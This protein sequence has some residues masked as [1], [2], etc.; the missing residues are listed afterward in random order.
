MKYNSLRAL[1]MALGVLAWLAASPS[2]GATNTIFANGV[3]WSTN[4]YNPDVTIGVGDYDKDPV[5]PNTSPVWTI[6][7]VSAT[8]TLT[9]N[10]LR[11]DTSAAGASLAFRQTQN[12]DATQDTT[13]EFRLRIIEHSGSS[14]AGSV[15]FANGAKWQNM[16]FSTNSVLLSGS[17]SPVSGDYTQWTL[18]RITLEDMTTTPTA[19]LYINNQTNVF[20]TSTTFNSAGINY[21]QFGDGSTSSSFESGIIEW[22]FVRWTSTGA[23][24]APEPSAAALL[25]LGALLF[26]ARRRMRRKG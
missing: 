7:N 14:Y 13:I 4:Y 11:I 1:T 3:D 20:S 10:A 19:K 8:R 16:Y 2:Q 17:G 24:P 26:S 12:W 6:S 23:F 18:F 15:L 21:L 25:A 9:N 22:D 5:G